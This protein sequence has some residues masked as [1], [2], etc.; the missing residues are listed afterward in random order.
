MDEDKGDPTLIYQHFAPEIAAAS[1]GDYVPDSDMCERFVRANECVFRDPPADDATFADA[2]QRLNDARRGGPALGPADFTQLVDVDLAIRIIIANTDALDTA[3]QALLIARAEPAVMKALAANPA[4]TSD[5]LAQ[6]AKVSPEA[7][8]I[9][10]ANPNAPVAEALPAD[11]KARVALAGRADIT[12]GIAVQLAM[13]IDPAVRKTLVKGAG[14]HLL[15]EPA[16]ARLARDESADVLGQ[17]IGCGVRL[18]AATLGAL[19]GPN[20]EKIRWSVAEHLKKQALWELPQSLTADQR[21]VIAEPLFQSDP[22]KFFSA[23]CAMTPD[24]QYAV[25]ADWLA[26]IAEGNR[27]LSLCKEFAKKTTSAEL[28]MLFAQSDYLDIHAELARNLALSP[29]AQRQ[30]TAPFAAFVGKTKKIPEPLLKIAHRLAEH[31]NVAEILGDDVLMLLAQSVKN[32]EPYVSM[33]SVLL[34]NRHLAPDIIRFIV[35]SNGSAAF[36]SDIA[37][38]VTAAYDAINDLQGDACWAALAQ[39][40]YQELRELAAGNVATPVETLLGLLDDAKV[41]AIVFSNSGLPMDHPAVLNSHEVLQHVAAPRLSDAVI[42]D[43]S[44]QLRKAGNKS[45]AN[46]LQGVTSRRALKAL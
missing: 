34:R 36:Q 17:F 30:L 11:A 44:V 40:E 41:R 42:A 7:R 20:D 5:H 22:R 26:N 27:N 21:H 2:W 14:V 4:T 23:A 16:L 38:S 31:E 15:D 1:F 8:P 24:A 19:A 46:K 28:M 33:G 32:V 37:H 10:A 6:I 35:E 3:T 13:D 18:D 25:G 12:G 45:L 9:V 39:S 43:L 29:A